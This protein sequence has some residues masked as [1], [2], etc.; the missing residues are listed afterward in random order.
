MIRKPSPRL[1]GL[2]HGQARVR[3]D[4]ATMAFVE[5]KAKSLGIATVMISYSI[6]YIGSDGEIGHH[7][8]KDTHDYA[9]APPPYFT[10]MDAAGDQTLSL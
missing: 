4:G 10:G 3:R 1:L 6:S 7:A 9:V 8:E 5:A 2:L